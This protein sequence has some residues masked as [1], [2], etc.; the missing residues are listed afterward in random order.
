M[1]SQN[2]HYIHSQL[3]FALDA[4]RLWLFPPFFSTV[5]ILARQALDVICERPNSLI[6]AAIL[7]F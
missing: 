7:S 5:A 1:C 6:I 2:R 3:P 4:A